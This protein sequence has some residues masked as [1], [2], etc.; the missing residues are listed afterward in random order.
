MQTWL[1]GIYICTSLFLNSEKGNMDCAKRQVWDHKACHDAS[2][3][4]LYDVHACH[5]LRWVTAHMPCDGTRYV[6][7]K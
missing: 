2:S 6:C 7:T 4:I 3:A 5:P 1:V